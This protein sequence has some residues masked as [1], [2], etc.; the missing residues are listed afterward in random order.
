MVKDHFSNHAFEY[1]QYRPNYPLELFDHI[2][3]LV[4]NR[5]CAWDCATGNGQVAVELAKHFNVVKATDVSQQQI[6]HA[7]QKTNIEYLQSPAERTPFADCTFDLI[8][9]AQA[10]HWFEFN[11]FF[12]EVER[13]S[14][15][16]GVIAIWGYEEAKV[17][18]DI[19]KLYLNFYQNVVGEHWP[20]ERKFIE[21]MYE[22]IEMP[23]EKRRIPDFNIR[24]DWDLN[25][26]ISYIRTW[27]AVQRYI[28]M[29]NEDPTIKLAEQMSAHWPKSLSRT[30]T[31]PLFLFIGTVKPCS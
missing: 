13:V 3:S 14:D 10:L 26:Y 31:F 19:D 4:P 21:T 22:T 18:N 30:V 23:F 9:V 7:I 15:F 2:L 28:G 6:D 27:S 25:D 8:T 11:D 17:N 29:H 24:M 12:K 5:N 20:E 1:S 16:D